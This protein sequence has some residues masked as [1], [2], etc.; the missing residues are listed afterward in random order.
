MGRLA[1][2]RNKLPAPVDTDQLFDAV[3][4]LKFLG[5][6]SVDKLQR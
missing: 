6:L 2:K 1:L 5:G 4:S 3:E